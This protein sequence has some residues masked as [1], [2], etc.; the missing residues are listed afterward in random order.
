MTLFLWSAGI[1]GITVEEGRSIGVGP[2][3]LLPGKAIQGVKTDG[4]SLAE[5]NKLLRY[6]K[7][8]RPAIYPYMKSRID[9]ICMNAVDVKIYDTSRDSSGGAWVAAATTQPYNPVLI[10]RTAEH[11]Y[12][13][14]H[15]AS[16][17]WL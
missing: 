17:S 9:V 12:P 1:A 15:A 7:T 10:Q 2:Y 11:R 6:L 4:T 13:R 14:H 16:P 3:N 5:I 8:Y